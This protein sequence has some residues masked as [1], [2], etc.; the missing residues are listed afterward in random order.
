MLAVREDY[1][2]QGLGSRL[3]TLGIE[4]MKAAGAAEVVLETEV[5]NKAALALYENLGFCRDKRLHR[6]YM[7]GS[8]AF[9]LKIWFE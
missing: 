7:N 2:K 8:D 9:R 1:R 5:F 4:S 3:V 6:Y